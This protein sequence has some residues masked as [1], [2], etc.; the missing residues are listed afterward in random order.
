MPYSALPSNSNDALLQL[1][2]IAPGVSLTIYVAPNGNDANTGLAANVPVFSLK[3]AWRLAQNYNIT[4]NGQLYVTFA[5]G[6]YAYTDADVPDNLYHPQGDNIILQGDPAAVKQRYLYR[7]QNYSWDISRISYHG[8]TGTANLT[9]LQTGHTHGFTA[10]DN[11]GWVAISNP[12]ISSAGNPT[13][14]YWDLNNGVTYGGLDDGSVFGRNAIYGD[15]FF[16]HGFSYENANGILGLAQIA[17]ASASNTDLQLIFKNTNTDPRIPA[18]SPYTKGSVSNGIGNA[19]SYNGISNNYPENQYSKPNG[20]YGQAWTGYPTR[21]GTD[22]WITNQPHLVTS[23]P[24][25]ILKSGSKPVF[26]VVGGNMK[27][28]RNFMVVASPFGGAPDSAARKVKALNALY[29]A[30]EHSPESVGSSTVLQALLQTQNA[31][32]GIRHLG[33]Y[34]AE[35]G[36]VSADSDIYTYVESD[37]DSANT[38]TSGVHTAAGTENYARLAH[39]DNTPVLNLVNV[40]YGIYAHRSKIGIGYE[41]VPTKPA[42]RYYY[43]EQGCFIQSG[44]RGIVATN[45]SNISLRSAVINST[46]SLPRFSCVLRVPVFAG[47]TLTTG[48]TYS[49]LSPLSWGGTEVTTNSNQA[50]QDTY[51]SGAMVVRTSVGGT[52]LGY[53][54]NIAGGGT[55]A[56][57]SGQYTT[58]HSV[59]GSPVP[60]YWQTLNV[61]GYRVGDVGGLQYSFDD[62]FS[63]AFLSPGTTLEFMAFSD[64][65][66]TR[67][68][69]TYE[70]SRSAFR[71]SSAAGQA[72]VGVTTPASGSGPRYPLQAYRANEEHTNDTADATVGLYNGS[73]LLVRK[74]IFILSGDYAGV[75]VTSGSSLFSGL[76]R[77][78]NSSYSSSTDDESGT[79]LIN[80][81]GLYGI[82]VKQAYANLGGVYVKNWK[83]TYRNQT[84]S[85]I[86]DL[87]T[88]IADQ[89]KVDFTDPYASVVTV[90][91]PHAVT[92][93]WS[94]NVG[95]V[96]KN[97][98]AAAGVLWSRY[99]SNITVE[100]NGTVFAS[101]YDGGTPESRVATP[102]TAL[103]FYTARNNSDLGVFPSGTTASSTEAATQYSHIWNDNGT[104]TGIMTRTPSFRYNQGTNSPYYRWWLTSGTRPG[105]GG[106]T[107]GIWA[108]SGEAVKK[109]GWVMALP[110]SHLSGVSPQ[111]VSCGAVS[112]TVGGLT[113]AGTPSTQPANNGSNILNASIASASS[114]TSSRWTNTVNTLPTA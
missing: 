34:H 45:S 54:T 22:N 90:F 76:S 12:S 110:F 84:G 36:I 73:S 28:I 79:I 70:I 80:G 71:L 46:R 67:A 21:V 56:Y 112:A 77:Q 105:G 9:N 109:V 114:D 78:E 57:S 106:R 74:N 60:A 62:N 33:V 82:W 88:I 55:F 47:G 7:V 97:T 40:R 4:G 39:P 85:T 66:T 93:L 3:Q 8:H 61:Y 95:D 49:F 37:T 81:A 14:S 15:M 41:S 27:A 107:A 89:S 18:F 92:G 102:R 32:V 65:E 2:T 69:G 16:N 48:N 43:G 98:N 108:T 58:T 86:C 19:I 51:A 104:N 17:N 6:T 59:A 75:A 20:Y 13:Y 64:N 5:G 50:F 96:C 31:K 68:G 38:T 10:A 30:E 42:S 29:P 25:T 11:N 83:P 52:T 113:Y 26:T 94:L 63:S 1:K 35:F 111:I 101:A 24:A 44:Y 72:I 23:F 100:P 87:Y 99:G 103:S 53:I 91:H